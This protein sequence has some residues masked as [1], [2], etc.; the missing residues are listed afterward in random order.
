M[1]IGNNQKKVL[2]STTVRTQVSTNPFPHIQVFIEMTH[3]LQAQGNISQCPLICCLQENSVR[4]LR[5]LKVTVLVFV[6]YLRFHSS[7]FHCVSICFLF[8]SGS[9][10]NQW[11]LCEY[12]H[13]AE[14]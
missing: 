1:K 4:G 3:G 13:V 10:S 5:C 7:P 12:H 9:F 11:I 6:Y 8:S 14:I 2:Q